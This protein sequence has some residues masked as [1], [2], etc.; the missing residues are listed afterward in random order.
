MNI[1]IL[2]NQYGLVVFFGPLGQKTAF[3]MN[4]SGGVPGPRRPTV[5]MMVKA[6]HRLLMVN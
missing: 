2:I 3:G 6:I 1:Q 4:H 5:R